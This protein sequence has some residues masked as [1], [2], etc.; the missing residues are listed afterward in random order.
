MLTS[1][2]FAVV[3]PSDMG[4]LFVGVKLLNESI[5]KFLRSVKRFFYC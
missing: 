1:C 4:A 3:S 2:M 5:C